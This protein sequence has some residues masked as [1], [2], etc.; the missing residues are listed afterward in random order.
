MADSAHDSRDPLAPPDLPFGTTP[1]KWSPAIG[2]G[3]FKGQTALAMGVQYNA[4]NDLRLKLRATASYVPGSND[5]TFGGGAGLE[6]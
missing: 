3:S 6:F 2:Y 5:V 4:D 1:G